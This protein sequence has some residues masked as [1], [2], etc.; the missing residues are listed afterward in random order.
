MPIT[1]NPYDQRDKA[2][3]AERARLRGL[4]DQARGDRGDLHRAYLDLLTALSNLKA[5]GVKADYDDAARGFHD[6]IS[7]RDAEL[8]RDIDAEHGEVFCP[9]IPAEPLD[10][11]DL[12]DFFGER[13]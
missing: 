7:N 11:S 8:R 12:E 6:A 13:A 9:L 5:C 1:L 3:F 10:L 2:A 4:A